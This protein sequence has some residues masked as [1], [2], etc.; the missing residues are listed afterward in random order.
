MKGLGYFLWFFDR[1]N[2][3]TC[4]FFLEIVLV[5]SIVL[6]L[7]LSSLTQS[8]IAGLKEDLRLI[9]YDFNIGA[10]LFYVIHMLVEVPF[11]LV[12]KVSHP[13]SLHPR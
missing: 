6:S 1:S 10:C 9:G 5:V 4:T 13:P 11:S 8:R 7:I 2:N 12:I 3:G